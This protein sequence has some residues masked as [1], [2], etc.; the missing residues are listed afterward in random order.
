MTHGVELVLN[1][2][3]WPK[4]MRTAEV[5]SKVTVPPLKTALLSPLWGAET[6]RRGTGRGCLEAVSVWAF[7]VCPICRSEVVASSQTNLSPLVFLVDAP[8]ITELNKRKDSSYN[9]DTETR[10]SE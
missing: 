7:L 3:Q 8:D 10:I 1:L 9:C 2:R 5:C 4:S 6:G